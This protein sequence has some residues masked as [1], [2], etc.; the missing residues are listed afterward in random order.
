MLPYSPVYNLNDADNLGVVCRAL[1][2]LNVKAAD[3]QAL[4]Y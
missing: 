2:M 4:E 1:N 3:D